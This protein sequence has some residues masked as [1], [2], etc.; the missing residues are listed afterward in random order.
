MKAIKVENLCK[1]FK[2]P[3]KNEN[4]SLWVRCRNYLLPKHQVVSAVNNI[5][6]EIKKGERVAFIGPNGAGKSTTIKMLSGI[7]DPCSGVV[8]VLGKVP[9]EDKSLCYDIGVVFGHVGNLWNSQSVEDNLK[10]LAAIYD[11]SKSD[12]ASSMANLCKKFNL[13][14]LLKRRVGNL[15][16]GER[17]RCEIASSFLHKPEVLFLDEPTI[18][19]DINAKEVIRDLIKEASEEFG[20]TILLTS[21]DT[22]DIEKL[23]ERAVIIDK[24]KLIFNNS[25]KQ[26]K[27]NFI[28]KKIITVD[29]KDAQ[30]GFTHEGVQ[31]VSRTPHHLVMEVNIDIVSAEDVI[32]DLLKKY[33]IRDLVIEAPSLESIIQAVYRNA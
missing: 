16:L 25:L 4:N 28:R 26:L 13:T 9:G 30:I 5:S 27:A 2:V 23:C 18:G 17:M 3:V 6:F 22:D 8:E 10:M 19:L 24:G 15:S 21:H 33:K 1:T 31:I 12:Y 7:M 14:T 29:T 11:I 32:S 20:T